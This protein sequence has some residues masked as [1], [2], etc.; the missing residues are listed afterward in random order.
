MYEV[1]KM[2]KVRT[3]IT[4]EDQLKEEAQEVLKEMGLSLSGAIELFLSKVVKDRSIPFPIT[5]DP[6]KEGYVYALVS[7]SAIGSDEGVD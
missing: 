6:T 2:A 4:I 7:L 3:T 5:A 1:A